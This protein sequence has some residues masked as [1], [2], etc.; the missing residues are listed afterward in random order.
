MLEWS[1]LF[2]TTDETR[3]F[4]GLSATVCLL[5]VSLSFPQSHLRASSYNQPR[6][7]G[8]ERSLLLWVV[9]LV[10]VV[11]SFPN[12]DFSNTPYTVF[13]M[14]IPCS[15]SSQ[16]KQLN[17]FVTQTQGL[18][19]NLSLLVITWIAPLEVKS[20]AH[21][22]HMEDIPWLPLGH[23]KTAVNLTELQGYFCRGN[24]SRE[25]LTPVLEDALFMWS[26]SNMLKEM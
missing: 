1:L 26:D 5:C 6:S 9:A 8:Y 25:P 4:C 2:S 10:V 13:Q 11:N 15:H 3:S 20:R 14:C 17:V 7:V 19:S 23:L 16:L 12:S 24:T 18:L 21:S 22:E